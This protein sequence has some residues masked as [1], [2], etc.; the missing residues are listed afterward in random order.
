MNN[1]TP[2]D[3]IKR[4]YVTEKTEMLH[5]LH[6]KQSNPSLAKFKKPKYVFIVDGQANKTEIASALEFIYAESK[7]QVVSVNVINAKRKRRVIRGK[8]GFRPG[9]KK[10]IVTLRAED[11]IPENV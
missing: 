10:A 2:Y 9:F 3:I 6:T 8:V 4:R 1:R 11:A 7:I 5:N